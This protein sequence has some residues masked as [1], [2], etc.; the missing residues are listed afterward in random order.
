MQR[1]ATPFR[2]DRISKGG[3]I[4]LYVREDISCKIIKSETDAYYE[5]FC[6]E[7]YLKENFTFP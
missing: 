1:Y 6:I 5:G 2:K 4:F 7:I 3:G